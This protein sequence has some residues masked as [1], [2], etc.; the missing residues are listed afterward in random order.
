MFSD[1]YFVQPT[2]WNPDIL[3]IIMCNREKHQI[4]IFERLEPADVCYF[5]FKKGIIRLSKQLQMNVL[6][7]DYSTNLCSST[8]WD[9]ALLLLLFSCLLSL[10]LE[11]VLCGGAVYYS[12]VLKVGNI[13]NI[14]NLQIVFSMNWSI[15]LVC[16]R[17]ENSEKCPSNSPKASRSLED[18]IQDILF[19]IMLDEANSHIWE[20]AT[21]K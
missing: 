10:H 5:C 9:W 7:I 2:V 14:I 18:D 19:N 6:S 1:K 4:L 11:A 17:L 15:I 21:K 13:F 12:V 16:K 20:A 8:H 3:F